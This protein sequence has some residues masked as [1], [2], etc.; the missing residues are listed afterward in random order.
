MDA[1]QLRSLVD[2]AMLNDNTVDAAE[3]QQILSI[4]MRD[5]VSRSDLV[6]ARSLLDESISAYNAADSI[7]RSSP[8]FSSEQYS[9]VAQRET[10]RNRW[11][12]YYR[13]DMAL[14]Y[15]ASLPA[16][17]AAGV[18]RAGGHVVRGVVS[19]LG[20]VAGGAIGGADFVVDGTLH[21]A[22]QVV[23]GVVGG[24][25]QV[26][27]GVFGG[28]NQVVHGDVIGG[29]GQIVGGTLNGAGTVAVGALNG[30]GTIAGGAL[31]G[32][33]HIVN[34]VL[35]GTSDFFHQIFN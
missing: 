17:A 22:G 19:G 7:A 32:A 16:Q 25:G 34:G 29:A 33:G 4:M 21:G 12:A 8:S 14:N 30:A 15:N 20:D 28:A 35:E 23:D 5:G 13:I 18:E 3:T 11:D 24:A 2:Q 31:N 26:A 9:A 1:V 6:A 10:A 27:D